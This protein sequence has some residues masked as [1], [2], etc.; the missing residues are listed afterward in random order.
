[1]DIVQNLNL[2]HKMDHTTNNE[3]GE[4]I[5]SRIKFVKPNRVR[6][7]LFKCIGSNLIKSGKPDSLYQVIPVMSHL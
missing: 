2:M 7:K 1:M 4:F 6:L 3:L 5:F